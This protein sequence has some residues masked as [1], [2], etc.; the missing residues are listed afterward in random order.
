MN[1]DSSGKNDRESF[2]L[3]PDAGSTKLSRRDFRALVFH[4]LYAWDSSEYDSS[5]A[6]VVDTFNRGFELDIPMEGEVVDTVQ[7]IA[8]SRKK[9]DEIITPLLK[10]WKLERVGYCTRLILWMG[11]WELLYSDT[12]STIV[13]NEAVE[14]AKNFSE[15]DAYKFVNGVMDEA[16]KAMQ[17]KK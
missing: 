6:S 2:E 5:L 13:I 3:G 1:D 15:K 14:L 7:A 11:V 4:L 10:N 8:D 17:K 16:L 9:V 12:P